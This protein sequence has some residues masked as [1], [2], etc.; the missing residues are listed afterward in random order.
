MF[1]KRLALIFAGLLLV[2]V[3][4]ACAP[5]PETTEAPTAA[6]RSDATPSSLATSAVAATEP[7]AA[8]ATPAIPD[9]KSDPQAAL[10]YAGG[11][12]K[13]ESAEF[14]YAMTMTMAPADDASAEA[15][16]EQA[17]IIEDFKMDLKGA[18]AIEIVDAETG[19][20]NMRMDMDLNAA[21]QQMQLEMIMIGETAW[22][23]MPGQDEWTKVEGEQARTALPTGVTPDQMLEDFKDAVDVQWIEDVTLNGE[24]VSHLRFSLDPSEI[25]L[26]ALTGSIVQGQDLSTEELEAMMKDMKPVVDVWLTKSGLELRAQKTE[27]D[28]VM[29]LPAEAN[30]G[31]AKLRILMT[32]DAEYSKVNEPVTIEPPAE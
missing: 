24:E 25:D 32:M 31:T 19:K 5:I 22:I 11:G 15:M 3:L 8:T 2:A 29:S 18:G 20:A 26:E 13:F 23:K 1:S 7:P 17:A 12:D 27:L 14:S 16:A 30:M 9:P 6:V 10:L 4:G 21:G 28:W